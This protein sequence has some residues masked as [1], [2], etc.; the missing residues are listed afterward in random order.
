MWRVISLFREPHEEDQSPPRWR[1]D[2]IQCEEQP[3]YFQQLLEHLRDR[4]DSEKRKQS[5]L[6]EQPLEEPTVYA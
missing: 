1:S 4:N 6:D 5:G 3:V 2:E